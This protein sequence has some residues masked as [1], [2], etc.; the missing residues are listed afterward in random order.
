MLRLRKIL[1]RTLVVVAVIYFGVLVNT[2]FTLFLSIQKPYSY[3]GKVGH[4]SLQQQWMMYCLIALPLVIEVGIPLVIFIS[5]LVAALHFYLEK[6]GGRQWAIFCGIVLLGV[7]LYFA[8][9][10]VLFIFQ[11]RDSVRLLTIFVVTSHF[12]VAVLLLL[13][14]CPAQSE[15]QPMFAS[16]G[17]KSAGRMAAL[18][19]PLSIAFAFVAYFAASRSSEWAVHH[20]AEWKGLVVKPAEWSE[21]ELIFLLAVF[22]SAFLHESGHAVVGVLWGRK[23]CKFHVGPLYLSRMEGRWHL[24]RPH[25][26]KDWI[27]CSTIILPQRYQPDWLKEEFCISAAG[28]TANLLAALLCVLLLGSMNPAAAAVWWN[29]LAELFTINASLL[30]VNLIPIQ[31]TDFMT[32]GARLWQLVADRAMAGYLS[33]C[34]ASF[35]LRHTEMR[36]GAYNIE[37][38]R[39]L[40]RR[41]DQRMD[42]VYLHLVAV[43]YYLAHGDMETASAEL[44]MAEEHYIQN[45]VQNRGYCNCIILYETCLSADY[46]KVR[47]WFQASRTAPDHLGPED[48]MLVLCAFAIA[49]NRLEDAQSIW[50]EKASLC[51]VAIESGSK[52]YDLFFLDLLKKRIHEAAEIAT[53]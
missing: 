29:M 7:S 22:M 16:A 44:Q 47:Q 14:F 51:A 10:E 31:K 52:A 35:A 19:G 50:T 3:F 37:L 17:E 2:C 1:A 24:Q 8:V 36:A 6:P 45:S 15:S 41:R 18:T 42:N 13:A 23:L 21:S 38:I 9:V 20:L 46:S 30:V 12:S 27:G 32:D 48:E 5:S 49:E 43:E 39:K 4:Y 33:I 25:G 53:T 28:L 26:I 34:S 11:F 40:I